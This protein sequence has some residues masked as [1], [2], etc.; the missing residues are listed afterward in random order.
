MTALVF[1]RVRFAYA[2]V[3]V[4]TDLSLAVAPGEVVALLGRNGAGK[5]TLTRLAMALLHPQAGDVRVAGNTTRGK[6]P[7]DMARHAAYLFQHPDQQLFARTALDEVLFAPGRLGVSEGEAR[8]RAGDALDAVG[9]GHAAEV[10]PHDLGPAERKLLTMAAC[11]AQRPEVLILDEPTL[12]LD[13]PATARAGT[14]V[15]DSGLRGAAVLA[16]THDLRFV[17]EWCHRVA[18]LREGVLAADL[19]VAGLMGAPDLVASLGLQL[20]PA[21]EVAAALGLPER[22]F[23]ER[24]VA[25]SIASRCRGS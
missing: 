5:T 14:A 6:A 11:L 21:A 4:L 19:P 7:E 2:T 10:H 12:G 24:D 3:P 1:D 8:V 22:P 25:R 9:L 23:T 16:V 20:P 18:V 17:A 15:R 13:R